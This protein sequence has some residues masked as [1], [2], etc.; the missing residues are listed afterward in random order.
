MSEGWE[1]LSK[2]APPA[3]EI[4]AV[5]DA[6]SIQW[7]LNKKIGDTLDYVDERGVPFRVRLVGAVA[8]SVLQGSLVIPEAELVRQG[9]LK[10]AE[11]LLLQLRRKAPDYALPAD[12]LE[13]ARSATSR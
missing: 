13:L 4:P 9:R 5:G 1:I 10:Q 7:A 11:E 2:V 12:L 3:D 8:N 6:Q